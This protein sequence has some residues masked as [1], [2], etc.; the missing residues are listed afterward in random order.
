MQLTYRGIPYQKSNFPTQQPRSETVYTYH[1]VTYQYNPKDLLGKDAQKTVNLTYR[2][3]IYTTETKEYRETFQSHVSE[4]FQFDESKSI[5][6]S[7][8]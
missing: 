3:V 8:N 4:A 5:V 6:L 1:G 2:G 7:R